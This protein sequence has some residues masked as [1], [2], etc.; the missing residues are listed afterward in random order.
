[1]N[2]ATAIEPVTELKTRSAQLIR[3]ARNSG[4]PIVITQN[5]K[6]T[7]VVQDVHSYQEQR[8]TLM[9]LRL[10][11]Q[12]EQDYDAGRVLTHDEAAAHFKEKL[13]EMSS[14]G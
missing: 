4:Q 6:A 12:G 10:L 8:D 14:R 5:G 1:M 3:D 11:V 2:M 9:M 13:A 7:A